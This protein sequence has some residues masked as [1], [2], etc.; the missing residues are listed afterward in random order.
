MG[1]AFT[2]HDVSK[3]KEALHDMVQK[4]KQLGVPVIDVDGELAIGFDRDALKKML[5]LS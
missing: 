5:D 3:D 1:V 2:D 4:S